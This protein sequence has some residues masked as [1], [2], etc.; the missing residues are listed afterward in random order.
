MLLSVLAIKIY[1]N[2]REMDKIEEIYHLAGLFQ[3]LICIQEKMDGLIFA[4]LKTSMHNENITS[5]S[6]SDNKTQEYTRLEGTK[7]RRWK[8]PGRSESQNSEMLCLCLSEG[9][10]KTIYTCCALN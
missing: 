9:K 10:Q 6:Q 2:D 3:Y 1:S 8:H 5:H 4:G 7:H